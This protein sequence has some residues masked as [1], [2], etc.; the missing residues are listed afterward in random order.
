MRKLKKL[1]TKICIINTQLVSHKR[2][3]LQVGQCKIVK[4][5][6]IFEC[7][8]SPA[9]NIPWLWEKT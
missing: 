5:G 4:L 3:S 9:Y 8:K 1:A 2:F 7:V 6:I